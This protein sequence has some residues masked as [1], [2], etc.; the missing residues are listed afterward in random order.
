MPRILVI[1]NRT[2]GGAAL[3][4]L[5]RQRVNKGECSVHLVVPAAA[6]AHSWTTSQEDDLKA[7]RRRLDATLRRFGQLGCEV[8]GEI[9]DSRPMDAVDDAL[10]RGPVDEV[11]VSTLPPGPSR[12]LRADLVSRLQ[13]K[14]D[15]PVTHVIGSEEPVRT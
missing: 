12:W 2:L 8:T 15:V 11:V 9:G 10:R 6:D 7:A 13:R 1:A 4:E 3:F 14:V 5:L